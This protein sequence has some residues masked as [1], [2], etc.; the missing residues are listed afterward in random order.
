MKTLLEMTQDILSTLDSDTVNSISDTY[1]ATQVSKIIR[2]V[3]LDIVTE[4]RLPSTHKL[5]YL[6]SVSD[7]SKPTHLKIPSGA[8]KVIWWKYDTRA[9]T[10]DQKQYSEV[11][12][13]SPEEFVELCN[14]RNSLDT[15]ENKVITLES[16]VSLVLCKTSR[17]TYYT[18]FDDEYIICDSYDSTVDTTLQQSKTQAFLDYGPT[19]SMTDNFTPILPENLQQLFFRTAENMCYQLFKQA[20][21]PKLERK[22]HDL[23]IRA[24]RN[25]EKLTALDNKRGT[26]PNY[27][28][29]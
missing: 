8:K 29:R 10:A 26:M 22:E 13:L 7:V 20:V 23:R 17:P 14:S 1:E 27:G 5:S 11:V 18:S 9:D 28:R 16:N 4:Y 24:Q 2:N 3:Y 19:F 12:Y 25:K 21:N 6:E 15:T